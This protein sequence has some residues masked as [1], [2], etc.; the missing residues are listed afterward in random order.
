MK[1]I[2]TDEEKDVTKDEI[3]KDEQQRCDCDAEIEQ[4]K[5]KYIRALADYRNLERR[6]QD[7]KIEVR[8][9]AEETILSRLLPVLGT[10]YKAST[11]LQDPG[12]SLAIKEFEAVLE[13]RG[14]KKIETVGKEFNPHEMECIEVVEGEENI[15]TEELSA[16]YTFHERILRV[17]QVKVGKKIQ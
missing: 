3:K 17:A 12:L 1:K 2:H 8:K 9:Y 16:G 6:T 10:F 14:V 13:E 15:V 5:N 7:E 11:H 4:W